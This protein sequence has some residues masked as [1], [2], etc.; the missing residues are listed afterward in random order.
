[1]GIDYDNDYSSLF[2]IAIGR[3]RARDIVRSQLLRDRHVQ[4]L[5]M[6]TLGQL[7]SLLG[8]ACHRLRIKDFVDMVI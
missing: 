4:L 2:I 7:C 1:L 8:G 5:H 6:R 3:E